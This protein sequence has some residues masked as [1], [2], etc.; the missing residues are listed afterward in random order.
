MLNGK[1][2]TGLLT[3]LGLVL[4]T[5][6]AYAFGFA[7]VVDSSK[8]SVSCFA[9]AAQ[10]VSIQLFENYDSGDAGDEDDKRLYL[11]TRTHG[12]IKAMLDTSKSFYDSV[13]RVATFE[14]NGFWGMGTGNPVVVSISLTP[15]A[16]PGY[17][18]MIV[19]AVKP[20]GSSYPNLPPQMFYVRP[21]IV[22]K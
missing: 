4:S 20:D 10:S 21:I 19:D 14:G 12:S 17:Y 6:V 7:G 16:T 1:R 3:V 9:T 15:H 2:Y 8:S 11:W 18:V 22:F 5:A 13:E